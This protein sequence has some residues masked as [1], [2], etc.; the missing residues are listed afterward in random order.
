MKS[1]YTVVGEAMRDELVN[2]FLGSQS[3]YKWRHLTVKEAEPP[4]SQL[5]LGLEEIYVYTS[6]PD[7][8]CRMK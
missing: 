1:K 8:F 3:H 7:G 4:W 5:S 2:R 6:L